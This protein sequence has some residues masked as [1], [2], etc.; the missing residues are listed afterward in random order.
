MI[1]VYSTTRIAKLHVFPSS[2]LLLKSESRILAKYAQ[3]SSNVLTKKFSKV[4]YSQ[5][6]N[7]GES[8]ND[9][10]K[11]SRSKKFFV[12]VG[13][14]LLI[15]YTCYAVFVSLSAFREIG[16]R[17]NLLADVEKDDNRNFEGTLLKYSP[18]QVLG[19]YEN[20]FP[21]YRIQTV[22]EFFFNRV[23][24]LFERNRGG[25]PPDPRQMEKLMPVHKPVWPSEIEDTTDLLIDYKI[26]HRDSADFHDGRN[27]NLTGPY[28]PENI[29]IYNTWLGQSCNYVMYN[30]LK[31]ITDPIFSEYLLREN[32]GP[33]RITGRPALITEVPEPDIILISH[34]HPDHLDMMSLDHWATSNT[35][36]IV[37]KGMGKFMRNHNV[38]NV[39]ELSWWD[40]CEL[41]KN[42]Q[43]Y[44]VACTPAMH[45][46]GR[47]VYDTNQSLWCTF[48]FS[49]NDR[50]IMFH[51]GDTG[52]V[53]DLFK[54]IG[55]RYGRGVRLALLPCGQY[56][57]EWHQR[58][59]HI[60]PNEVIKIMNDLKARNVL[61]VHWGTFLL[62]GEYFLEPKEKLEQLA[63]FAG[64]RDNCYC[65]ELG[66]TIKFE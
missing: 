60:N 65:P 21:E 23:V 8:R 47:Y 56:C 18:L 20:P 45:W 36:W 24:E 38:K 52:Y 49:H 28:E 37:P 43:N 35:L 39:I 57:P 26:V 19:R 30:G 17:N 5:Q 53:N 54:R 41:I 9:K 29:P 3:S 31:I 13:F 2:T 25:I 44:E 62:S 22:Y 6:A 48:M 51:G 15:P 63:V 34:N 59:R 1:N 55:E 10:E 61:G 33:K 27:V 11:S 7:Q 40:K 16:I 32:I 46:S 64:I 42:N 14:G 4:F 58:P 66:E 12:R 50:P